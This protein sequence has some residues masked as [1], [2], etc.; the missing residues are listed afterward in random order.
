[1]LGRQAACWSQ[2]CEQRGGVL[3]VRSG[4]A[5]SRSLRRRPELARALARSQRVPEPTVFPGPQNW[6]KR[7]KKGQPGGLDADSRC[8]S[9]K[10]APLLE[11]S[12]GEG[13]LLLIE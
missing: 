8:A 4:V 9:I 6:I 13:E 10:T 2:E 12:A 3:V 11:R 7:A 1:M 5:F